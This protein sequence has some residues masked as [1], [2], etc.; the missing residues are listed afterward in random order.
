VARDVGERGREVEDRTDHLV[1]LAGSAERRRLQVL[2][3][4]LRVGPERLAEPRLDQPGAIGSHGL[5]IPEDDAARRTGKPTRWSVRSST[6]A[7]A[8][9]YVTGH[10][11]VLDGGTLT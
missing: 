9:A 2:A 5:P 1:G 7:D 11:I 8:S 6:R 4:D 3:E 10:T